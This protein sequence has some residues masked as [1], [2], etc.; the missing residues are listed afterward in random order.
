ML[1]KRLFESS[2]KM[3]RSSFGFSNSR[4]AMERPVWSV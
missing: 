1:I 2:P 3:Q 4:G